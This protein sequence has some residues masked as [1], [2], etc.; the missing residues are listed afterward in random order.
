MTDQT[1]AHQDPDSGGQSERTIEPRWVPLSSIDR[2]V[3]GVLAEKAKTTPDSYPLSLNAVCSG[4]NQKSN[5][6]PIMQLEPDDVEES[7]DRLREMGAVGIVQG[8]GRVSKYRHYLYEWLGVDKLEMAVMTELLLRGDQTEGELRGRAA[9]M[10]PI[11]GLPELRPILVSLKSKG[12]VIPLTPEGRGHTVTHA[13]YQPHEL[14]RLKERYGSGGD[15]TTAVQ[16]SRP[17]PKAHDT[18]PQQ[19]SREQAPPIT[20][21]AGATAIDNDAAESLRR[22]LGELRDQ[23][24][25]LRGDLDEVG[26]RLQRTETE[27]H[28]LKDAL[29]A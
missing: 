12:L 17:S 29:G 8:Y 18:A 11:A 6:A 23:V 19:P 26:G 1:D 21:S 28:E 7:L 22:E 25:Q 14:E 16:P 20:A 13:L 10:E 9:R 24:A 5:R 3:A 4:C 2:R 15:R 27:L